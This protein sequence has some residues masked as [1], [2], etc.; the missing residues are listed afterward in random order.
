[1][2]EAKP[3]RIEFY[4]TPEGKAPFVSW[5]ENKDKTQQRTI[6]MRLNRVKNGNYGDI[7]SVGEGVKE[8]KFKE[9]IRIYFAEVAG[10]IVLLLCSGDK[11]SQSRDIKKAKEFLREFNSRTI[12]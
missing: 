9:G 5:F 1:M 8:F 2:N 11:T 4:R 12:K 3:K 6:V 7:E 10:S